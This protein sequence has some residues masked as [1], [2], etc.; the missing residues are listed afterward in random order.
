[1][2]FTIPADQQLNSRVIRDEFLAKYYPEMTIKEMNFVSIFHPITS[3]VRLQKNI[4]LAAYFRVKQDPE[5]GVTHINVMEGVTKRATMIGA[6]FWNGLIR[7]DFYDDLYRKFNRWLMTKYNLSNQQVTVT[8]PWSR[9]TRILNDVLISALIVALFFMIDDLFIGFNFGRDSSRGIP[10]ALIMFAAIFGVIYAYN[11][12]RNQKKEKRVELLT[13]MKIQ[14]YQPKWSKKKAML[15]IL[16]SL[17]PVIFLFVL[18]AQI[19]AFILAFVN[20]LLITI[21]I[22]VILIICWLFKMKKKSATFVAWLNILLI[23]VG[24]VL[25]IVFLAHNGMFDYSSMQMISMLCYTTIILFL[26]TAIADLV[27]YVKWRRRIKASPQ[28]Q[29][30]VDSDVTLSN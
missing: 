13:G 21:L 30:T 29:V 2:R 4:A 23:L 19:N 6:D 27:M 18:A 22:D 3:Y 5:K 28:P 1:M 20:L 12:K 16:H 7:G 24:A 11:E 25:L 26:V 10:A 14:P 17:L 8:K 15:V 9:T